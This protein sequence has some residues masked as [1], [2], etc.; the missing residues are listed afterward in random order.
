VLS[1]SV[2]VIHVIT[3]GDQLYLSL[4]RNVPSPKSA[5]LVVPIWWE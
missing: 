4:W 2:Q 5:I 3:G 1:V